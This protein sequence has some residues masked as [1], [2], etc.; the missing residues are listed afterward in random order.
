QFTVSD[1]GGQFVVWYADSR[2]TMVAY[3]SGGSIQWV[4]D[5][6]D[7]SKPWG[8]AAISDGRNGWTAAPDASAAGGA[9]ITRY[10][11]KPNGSQGPKQVWAS[12]AI[13]L[14]TTVTGVADSKWSVLKYELWGGD[15]VR[16]SGGYGQ[17]TGTEVTLK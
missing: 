8:I 5:R 17:Y 1:S 10:S 16:V 3:T 11:T 14:D 7:V 9:H 6:S 4:Q 12:D 15:R 2:S 13:D